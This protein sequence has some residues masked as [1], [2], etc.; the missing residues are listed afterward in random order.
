ML[1]RFPYLNYE[2]VK[3]LRKKLQEAKALQPSLQNNLDPVE[4]KVQEFLNKERQQEIG[5]N[6][7]KALDSFLEKNKEYHSDNDPGSLKFKVIE[8]ELETYKTDGLRSVEDFL[9]LYKKAKRNV[10]IN[11][12]PDTEI[13]DGEN[14][15][16]VSQSIPHSENGTKLS[17]AEKQL[18]KQAGWTEERFLKL[19]VSQPRYLQDLLKSTNL[20]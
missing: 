16:P 9:N 12:F 17:S 4:E 18:L 14:Q 3:D 7:Q 8:R 13:V 10:S 15:E 1:F 5:T 6:K 19:K 2:E 11:N 20:L